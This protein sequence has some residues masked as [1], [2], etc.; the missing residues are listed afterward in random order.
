MVADLTEAENRLS[1]NVD[2]LSFDEE[3]VWISHR[4]W[5]QYFWVILVFYT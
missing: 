3:K 4:L 2:D 5:A 1:S